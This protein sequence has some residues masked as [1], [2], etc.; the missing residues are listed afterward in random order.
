MPF[1]SV[2][3][4]IV[5]YLWQSASAF[6]GSVI[7]ESTVMGPVFLDP[8]EV[9]TQGNSVRSRL[10]PVSP[11]YSS[12]MPMQTVSSATAQWGKSVTCIK[13]MIFT[14]LQLLPVCL[15]RAVPGSSAET[16]ATA[17]LL[18]SKWPSSCTTSALSCKIIIRSSQYPVP[19]LT[20]WKIVAYRSDPWLKAS[21][22]TDIYRGF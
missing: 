1:S 6:M 22:P 7:T 19:Y 2:E 12:A 16:A 10:F 5:I 8:A 13:L 9:D 4:H 20:Y 11:P 3:L 15:T 17:I 21:L 14:V 18:C